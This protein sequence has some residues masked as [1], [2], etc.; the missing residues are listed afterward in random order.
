M[1]LKNSG[2]LCSGLEIKKNAKIDAKGMIIPKFLVAKKNNCMGTAISSPDVIQV[3]LVI[4][5]GIERGT[6]DSFIIHPDHL[7]MQ[8]S[9]TKHL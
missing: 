9:S 3:Q 7:V 4:R 8:P 5:E 6:S 2:L 1:S